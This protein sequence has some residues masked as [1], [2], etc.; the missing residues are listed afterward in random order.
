MIK[1][2]EGYISIDSGYKNS[3]NISS[4]LKKLN[5]KADEVR[6]VFLTHLDIDH[7]GGIDINSEIVFPRAKIYLGTEENKYLTGEYFRKKIAF[8]RCKL[9]IT[10]G[11]DIYLLKNGEELEIGKVRV[12]TLF[13]PGHISYLVN[14]SI[15][16]TGDSI[17][18]NEDGGYS[19][20]D[21]W[22]SDSE[23]NKQSLLDLK[24]KM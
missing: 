20:Y 5:I 6:V 13:T 17:I 19:F 3:V 24:K 14:D 22:N 16:F 11:K 2:L 1:T 8:I 15:L 10:L 18:G 7:A 9:P 23:Q 4:G 21:F 12:K